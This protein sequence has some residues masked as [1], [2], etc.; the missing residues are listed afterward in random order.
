MDRW[1]DTTKFI[2]FL[3]CNIPS[4]LWFASLA[5]VFWSLALSHNPLGIRGK[6]FQSGKIFGCGQRGI[7][8]R[9]YSSTK[10][11]VFQLGNPKC[12]WMCTI[13][14]FSFDCFQWFWP[15][16]GHFALSNRDTPVFAAA[17]CHT[18]MIICNQPKKEDCFLEKDAWV[19][20]VGSK[21][22]HIQRIVRFSQILIC[23]NWTIIKEVMT[24]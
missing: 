10:S 11:W 9:H 14:F 6:L 23:R 2:I 21:H 16:V 1:T 8:V 15:M 3:V 22:L 4:Y 24:I 7:C 5:E 17:L 12:G 19:N 20:F 18:Q 13:F